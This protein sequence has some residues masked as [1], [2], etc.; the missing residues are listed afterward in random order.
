MKMDSR[1]IAEIAAAQATL[2]RLNLYAGIHK[3]LRAFM[4]DSLLALGRMDVDDDLERAQTCHQVME[5]LTLCRSHL[6]HEN[7]FIHS[8]M[9]ARAPGTSLPLAHEH[10]AH[11]QAILRLAAGV[12]ALLGAAGSQRAALAQALYTELAVFVGHNYEHMQVEESEH[13]AVLWAHYSDAEL[14]EL[15][16]TLVASIP[17]EETLLIMRWMIPFMSPAERGA[18]LSDMR[19]HAPAPALAAVLDTV[20]P[21]L[22]GAEWHKLDRAMEW[23]GA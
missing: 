5:L 8:A 3:G 17:P 13:N 10:E 22:T 2:A 6:G 1:E 11:E 18:L 21:H 16:N 20:R 14:M 23:A 12:T 4:A 9:E 19:A 15:H 7:R